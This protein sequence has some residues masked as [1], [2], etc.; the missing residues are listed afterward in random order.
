MRHG[1]R[2]GFRSRTPYHCPLPHQRRGANL[3]PAN[4]LMGSWRSVQI[5]GLKIKGL[6]GAIL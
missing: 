2:D 3:S 1:V 6:Q 5:E 4:L